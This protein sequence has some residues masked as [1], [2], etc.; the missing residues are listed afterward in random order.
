MKMGIYTHL[1]E[2]VTTRKR[3]Y[4][5]AKLEKTDR[6]GWQL[7][8][9]FLDVLLIHSKLWFYIKSTKVK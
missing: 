6:T 5:A 7:V 9:V 2:T 1:M 3:V 4:V 8:E